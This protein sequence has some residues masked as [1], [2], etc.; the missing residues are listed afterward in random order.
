MGSHFGF[1]MGTEITAP[2]QTGYAFLAIKPLAAGGAAFEQANARFIESV[3]AACA[4]TGAHVPGEQARRRRE[5]ALAAGRVR[6]ARTIY[7][8]LL[9]L[10]AA[11]DD[12]RSRQP[13]IVQLQPNNGIRLMIGDGALRVICGV[14]SSDREIAIRAK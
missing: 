3:K 14:L 6:V 5:E 9:K 11:D 4:G 1:A 2:H 13:R 10:A 7:E 12:A 8:R